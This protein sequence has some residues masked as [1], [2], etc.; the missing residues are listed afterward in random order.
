MSL[1]NCRNELFAI[2]VDTCR[3]SLDDRFRAIITSKNKLYKSHITLPSASLRDASSFGS[4]SSV[5]LI[6]AYRVGPTCSAYVL[7]AV[8]AE[9]GDNG[10]A[11]IR[12]RTTA[13]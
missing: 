10:H 12:V 13:R 2:K 9:Y 1:V 3:Y 6:Y 4:C 7:T 11:I 5:A 8:T